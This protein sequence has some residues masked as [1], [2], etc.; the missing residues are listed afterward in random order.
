M[1]PQQY[2]NVVA[3]MLFIVG[4]L[5]IQNWQ[6]HNRL[7]RLQRTAESAE[8]SAIDA[9]EMAKEAAGRPS[10]KTPGTSDTADRVRR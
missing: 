1:N 2:R 3:L 8:V 4:A 5:V 6:L 7:D 10:F 9:L